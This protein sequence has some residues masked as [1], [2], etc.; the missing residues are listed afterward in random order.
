MKQFLKIAAVAVALTTFAS[1]AAEAQGGGGGGGGAA[2]GGGQGRGG[3]RGGVVGTVTA[4]GV[5]ADS[6]YMVMFAGITLEPAKKALVMPLITKYQADMRANPAPARGGGG[7]GGARGGGT[8]PD[9]ATMAANAAITAKR[10]G[11]TTALRV[12][13]KKQL[14]PAQITT[15]DTT[16]PEP[17][18]GRGRGGF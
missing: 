10:N 9:S 7:G 12:E 18:A 15:F 5:S 2:R 1:A 13:I 17:M 16:F 6:A 4:E 8:P 3:G 14:T 11:F